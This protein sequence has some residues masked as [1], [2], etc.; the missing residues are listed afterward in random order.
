MKDITGWKPM[1][2]IHIETGEKM[3]I[4][5]KLF[6]PEIFALP[7]KLPAKKTTK[8]DAKPNEGEKFICEEHGKEF[9]TA[10]ALKAHHT[11]YHGA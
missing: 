11:R 2:V 9:K 3:V 1:E 10:S 4:K 8:N 5:D 6:N 7:G